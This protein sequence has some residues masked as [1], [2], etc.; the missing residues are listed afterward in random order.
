MIISCSRR[1]D[2]PAFYS[3]W[4]F[5]RLHERFVRVRNPMNAK[6]VRRI[7]LS[8]ADV[9]CI[10]FWTK[11]P[12]PML[13]KLQL[14][15]DY[16]F[17]FQ[18]TLTPYGKDI[19]PNLPQKTKIIDSFRK[20]SDR[21]GE[22][23]NIWRYDPIILSDGMN[24]EYHIEQFG[25]LAGRLSDYTEKCII[26]FLD[27]Y[28]HIQ[29]RISDLSIRLPDEAE[30]RKLAK[31]IS[32]IAGSHKIKVETCAEA[33][34]LADLGIEHG[35]CINDRLISELTGKSLKIEKDKHQRELCGCVTGVD[36]GE[37]NTCRHLCSYCYANVS[38]KKVKRNY[39]LHCSQS[40]L[41]IGKA[42]DMQRDNTL[43]E[44]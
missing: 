4:F 28:R 20:L 44:E 32:K 10:V 42:N 14:L 21:T 7:S 5:N 23:R 12:T 25:D 30:M 41:L 40:P 35:K 43:A 9:D 3:D 33:V 34:N 18:F 31:E 24:I 29:S 15:S 2:I 8:P 1:T 39:S 6:Q 22:K 26:S 17:Y 36:I 16:N 38:P 37:Y 27:S 13:D 19:E 11:D